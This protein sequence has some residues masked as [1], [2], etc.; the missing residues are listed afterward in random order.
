VPRIKVKAIAAF[1]IAFLLLADGAVASQNH[2]GRFI[3]RSGPVAYWRLGERSG[4]VAR[5]RVGPYAGSYKGGP[6]LDRKGLLRKNHNHAP[7]FDGRDDRVIAN[8]LTSR[9]S[10]SWSHGYT[11]DAWVM[12]ST[13]SAEEH[14]LAFNNAKGGNSIAVFRDEPSNKFKFR[15]CEGSG[16]VSVYSKTTPVTGKTYQ[17]VVTV[18][19]SNHGRLYVNGKAQATFTSSKRPPHSAL[20]TI[21]AEYDCCPTP[22]SFWHGKIDEV[23]VYDHALSAAQVAAQWATGS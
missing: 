3:R 11:L 23:A 8:G 7:R 13:T 18:D 6:K 17:V 20:F 1:L 2:Y 14:I 15:D 21:G 19:G 5:P 12:T 9:S 16:C 22:T 4:S 10:S